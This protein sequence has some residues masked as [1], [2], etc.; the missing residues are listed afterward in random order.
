MAKLVAKPA[1][2]ASIASRTSAGHRATSSGV[3]VA[4]RRLVAHHVDAQRRVADVGGEVEHACRAARP[5]P[6]TRGTSRSPT[7]CRPRARPASMSSTFSRVRAISS[8]S[9]GR[10]RGDREAAVAGDDGGDAVEA[11]RR[12]RRVPE[13][14]GVVVGVDVDEAGGDHA[15]GGVELVVAVRSSP[16]ST[17]R[18]PSIATSARRPGAPVPS[19]TVPPRITVVPTML[20]PPD[21]LL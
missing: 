6:G 12:Q 8:R 9:L 1:A 13:H 15:A 19:T 17:I 18:P 4:A 7:G 5:R 10:R 21:A 16:I 14:L 2:P 3:A 11:R 20:R